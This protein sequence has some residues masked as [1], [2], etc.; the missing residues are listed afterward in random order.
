MLV[1]M[2]NTSHDPI[3]EN[4]N[5]CQF[6]AVTYGDG[7]L[8]IFAGAGSGKTRVLTHRIAYLL[9]EGRASAEQVFAVT[10][11]NKAANEMKE[12]IARLMGRNIRWMWVGTFHAMCARLLRQYGEKIGIP[13]NFIIFD[14]DDQTTMVADCCEEFDIDPKQ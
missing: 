11:T 6:E 12:R 8:L 9:R 10:F 1:I 7:P 2:L 5:P 13:D 4:L 3:L 14:T